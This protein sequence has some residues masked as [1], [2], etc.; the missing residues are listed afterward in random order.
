MDRNRE[1]KWK[2]KYGELYKMS[3]LMLQEQIPQYNVL[4]T[5]VNS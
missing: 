4:M 3:N 5:V 1:E 2:K